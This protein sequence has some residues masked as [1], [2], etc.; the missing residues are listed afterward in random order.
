MTTDEGPGR[1][2]PVTARKA[3]FTGKPRR[4]GTTFQVRAAEVVARSLITAG[5]LGTILAV[6][7]IFVFL[8]MVVAPLFTSATL[9]NQGTKSVESAGITAIGVDRY[10]AL[11]WIASTDGR[12]LSMA[13]DRV[14][15][16]DE[17]TTERDG[18]GVPTS[19][20]FSPT[21]DRAVLGYED[22]GLVLVDIGFE[23]DYLDEATEGLGD[24]EV[25]ETRVFE[26]WAVQ[27]TPVGQLRATRLLWEPSEPDFPFEGSAVHLADATVV[28][29]SPIY[30]TL[31]ADGQL[32]LTKIRVR[33]SMFGGETRTPSSIELPYEEPDGAGLPSALFLNGRGS[34]VM[35]LWADGTYHRYRAD[36]E[37]EGAL[38]ET[39]DLIA[40]PSARA[41]AW[42]QMLGKESIV[43][44]DDSGAVATW[45]LVRDADDPS[46]LVTVT[47][48]SM[49]K[50]VGRHVT[51]LTPSPSS[52]LVVGGTNDGK[53]EVY[54]ATTHRLMGES[55][56]GFD[57]AVTAVEL[58]AEETSIRAALGSSLVTLELDPK[59]PEA[60]FG[61]LFGKVWYEGYPE[62]EHV[63]QS[64]GGTDEF[65]PKLGMVSLIYGTLKATIYSMM[66]GAPL[67]ILAAIFTSEFLSRRLRSK[68]KTVMELMASLPSV[69][70]GFLGGLVIA[71][72]VQDQLAGVIGVLFALPLAFLFGAHLWQMIPRRLALPWNN[73]WQRFGLIVLAIPIAVAVGSVAGP[74]F[75]RLFFGGNTQ[76][77]L[78]AESGEGATG[79]WA[80][81]ILPLCILAVLFVITRVIDP[82][83]R[84]RL[85]STEHTRLARIQLVKF[86]VGGLVALGLAFMLGFGLSAAGVDPRGGVID[87]YVQRNALV[88]G[89]VMGFAI[90]PIIYTLAEDALSSVPEHLRHASLGAGATP[91]QTAMRV[92]VPTAMS[93]LFSAVMIGLG[94]AVGETMI[95]LMATGNTPIMEMNIFNGFRTLS[96]NIAVELPEAV[97]ESTHFR[98]LFLAAL[99]LFAM[100]FVLNTA[101]EIVRQRFR[102]R[103]YQL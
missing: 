51:A 56:L 100:T 73:G 87:T 54:H 2:A 50:L 44:A 47:S 39:Q 99:T 83:L 30:A 74:A 93:G 23:E 16:I 48:G 96:A 89:F 27:R 86:V 11:K 70:L 60:S 49:P 95:V 85:V 78:A 38:V 43:L 57:A 67:A 76:S 31:T 24:L 79:G 81:L 20:S 12:V 64:T 92:I 84:D 75:E 46:R 72:F 58:S 59:Y 36:S 103:A 77:W 101:A 14:E 40:D 61:T 6:T 102:K 63:W 1:Q 41:S 55:D 68:V 29:G 82:L 19:Q 42:T 8:L 10:E 91:W 94:R 5:G 17:L 53:V 35:L 21:L 33:T 52:R 3:A 80:L 15:V 34:D 9:E 32:A 69:V 97:K 90:I 13:A 66:F 62:P 22:G 45:F 88:V 7:L 18:V 28:A 65:E 71:P 26:G 25:G 37:G 98:V 4:R